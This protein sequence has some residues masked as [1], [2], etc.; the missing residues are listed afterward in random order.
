VMSQIDGDDVVAGVEEGNWE[1]MRK[2]RA[3]VEEEGVAKKGFV[4]IEVKDLFDIVAN[5]DRVENG[6]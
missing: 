1:R 2:D 3:N 6:R 5:V 4:E